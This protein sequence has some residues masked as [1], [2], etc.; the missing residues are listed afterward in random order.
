MVARARIYGNAVHVSQIGVATF[1]QRSVVVAHEVLQ[2][3]RC[4]LVDIL[5]AASSSPEDK[6]R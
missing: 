2:S 4:L 6:W 5:K 1:L 3:K